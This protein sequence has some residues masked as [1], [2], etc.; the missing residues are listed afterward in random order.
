MGAPRCSGDPTTLDHR[1]G[2]KARAVLLS[3]HTPLDLVIIP[4]GTND[5]KF[6]NRCRAFDA[7]MDM[8]RR[9]MS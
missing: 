2:A 4:L 9:A 7:S 3:T 8:A 5:I 1:N 6:A